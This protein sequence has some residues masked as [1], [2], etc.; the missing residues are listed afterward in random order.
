MLNIIKEIVEKALAYGRKRL[1][2][3]TTCDRIYWKGYVCACRDIQKGI[4]EEMNLEKRINYLMRYAPGDDGI[5]MAI[6]GETYTDAG[7]LKTY[8]VKEIIRGV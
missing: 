8:Q 6:E 4:E 3:Q 7:Y 1:T 5:M 2:I